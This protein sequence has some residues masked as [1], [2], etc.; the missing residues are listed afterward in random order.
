MEDFKMESFMNGLYNYVTE[1]QPM[2]YMLVAIALIAIGILYIIPSE[3]TKGM[4]TSALPFVAIGCG[5]VVL[6]TQFAEEI[7]S[8]FVF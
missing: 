3:K 6:A 7:S 2:V 5:L 1:F 4:A 8:K